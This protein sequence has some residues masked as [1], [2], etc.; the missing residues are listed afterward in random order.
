MRAIVLALF[1][2]SGCKGGPASPDLAR[3]KHQRR[4]H[5]YGDSPFFDDGR[6][7][8]TPPSGTVSRER[9][10]GNPAFTEGVVDGKYV[11]RIPIGL[12]RAIVERGRD[13]YDVYCAVCH[14][15]D[16]D[17]ESAVAREMT[18]RHPPAL[19]DPV[20]RGFPPG[21]IFQVASR[22]YGLMPDYASA[23]SPEDRWAVVAYVRALQRSQSAS[24]DEMPPALRREAERRLP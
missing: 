5:L 8:R 4:P 18:L 2:L 19:T 12:N 17:A 1:A 14:S 20:V 22:G 10:L 13:R 15:V 21:R 23:L 3:M 9:I 24:L 16:G 7:M 6:A 11:E